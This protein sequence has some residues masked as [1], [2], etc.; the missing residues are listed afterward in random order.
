MMMVPCRLTVSGR[1]WS[2]KP[3]VRATVKAPVRRAVPGARPPTSFIGGQ[4]VWMGW[5]LDCIS[6]EAVS[7]LT[8]ATRCPTLISTCRG[9]APAEVMVIVAA[10]P[11]GGVAVGAGV[12][13]TGFDGV[14]DPPPHAP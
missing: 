6:W 4:S 9:F 10:P 13:V 7:L 8:K 2:W 1:P 14:D 3:H 11:G 12:G 5:G